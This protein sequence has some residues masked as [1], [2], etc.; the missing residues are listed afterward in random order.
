[1]LDIIAIVSVGGSVLVSLI[2]PFI[3]CW[4]RRNRRENIHETL[5]TCINSTNPNLDLNDDVNRL[6]EA[7]AEDSIPDLANMKVS[8]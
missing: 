3:W 2:T 7:A 4:L 1:M 5:E 8:S 6:T